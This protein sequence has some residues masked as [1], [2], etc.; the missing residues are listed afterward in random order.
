[1]EEDFL[2]SRKRKYDIFFLL[3]IIVHYLVYHFSTFIIWISFKLYFLAL[4][5]FFLSWFYKHVFPYWEDK[6][7]LFAHL[8]PYI[9]IGL[10]FIWCDC[11]V[12]FTD[13]DTNYIVINNRHTVQIFLEV[14]TKEKEMLIEALELYYDLHMTDD[15]IAHLITRDI[16]YI[17]D[18][19]HR[20]HLYEMSLLQK[21]W[22]Y[23]WFEYFHLVPKIIKKPRF[24]YHRFYK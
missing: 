21:N 15:S 12:L 7:H 1:M 10:F 18:V 24:K 14:P 2:T 22:G 6:K 13:Y 3:F 5:L 16:D 8:F 11:W 4:F 20:R 17:I 19:Y 9:V 23:C